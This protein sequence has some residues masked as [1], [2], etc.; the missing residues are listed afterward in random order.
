MIGLPPAN[1]AN[2]VRVKAGGSNTC[3]HA[4]VS[5]NQVLRQ[6]LF[7]LASQSY[8]SNVVSFG[9]PAIE[10]IDNMN[11]ESVGYFGVGTDG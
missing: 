9:R 5:P 4:T 1:L 10:C 2:D 7:Q 8:I 11:I 3:G 6:S